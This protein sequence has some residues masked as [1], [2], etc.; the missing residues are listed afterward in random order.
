MD[1]LE[2]ALKNRSRELARRLTVEAGFSSIQAERFL[3]AAGQALVRSYEWQADALGPDSLREATTARELLSG[4]SGRAVA[5]EVGLSIEQAWAGLRAL[6]PEVLRSVASA[7]ENERARSEGRAG[8]RPSDEDDTSRFEIG[9]GLALDRVAARRGAAGGI[10]TARGEG[11]AA[12]DGIWGWHPIFARLL[13]HS[14][15]PID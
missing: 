5:T 3:G 9:F 8:P 15:P 7:Y 6:V 1:I 2:R 4:I 13:R 14:E 12:R 10:G 11:A